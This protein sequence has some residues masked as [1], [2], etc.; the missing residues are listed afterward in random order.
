VSYPPVLSLQ[1]LLDGVVGV[2]QA[3]GL[4]KPDTSA[5]PQR[6][7]KIPCTSALNPP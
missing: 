3:E 5:Q 6:L 7:G 2:L 4:T 1:A